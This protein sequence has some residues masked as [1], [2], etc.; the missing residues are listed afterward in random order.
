MAEY[1]TDLRDLEFSLFEWLKIQDHIEDYG[2]ND[3]KD[4]INQ[5]DKFIGNEVYPTRTNGDEEGV[6]LKDGQVTV[7]ESFHRANQ[8]FYENGWFALGYP[9]DIGGMP[10]PHALSVACTS[11]ANGANVSWTMYYGLSRAAMNVIHQVGSD[12]Q[13]NKYI[14]KMMEGSWGG[15]MCLTEAGAGSDVGA[16][17][18]TATPVGEDKFKI[19]GVKIFISSGDNDLYKNIVHLVL[20]RTPG[21]P[22]GTKGL[23]L[24]IVPKNIINED[25]S[26]GEFN[27]VR[28]TK[29]EE[30]MGLHG[31]A[32]CELTFGAEGECIGEMIGNEHEGIINMFI[33]MNEARLLC[34]MQGESQANLAYMLTEQ[35]ANERVQFGTEI[36]KLH[37]VKRMMLKMRAMSRGLR[38]LNL[39]AANLFDKIHDDPSIENKVA[40]LTPICKS[41][42]SEAGFQV[43]ID[44][45]QVHGGYG[46]CSE[47]GIEQFARDTKIATIYEG[48]NAI[49]A[50]DFSTRKVLKDGG[51]TLNLFVQEIS[52]SLESAGD[53]W[54]AECAL[55]K[56]CLGDL[57]KIMARFG[58]DA[59]EKKM[60][61]IL[62]N[63]SDF[64]TYCGNLVLSWLLLENALLSRGKEDD[65]Y[66]SK[67]VDFKT[68]CQHYLTTNK[69][70][71]HTLTGFE[72]DLSTVEL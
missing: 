64:L 55:I 47:Y 1:K 45:I 42:G 12:D 44:A 66:K 56:E 34:G 22:E 23:S 65:Y 40:F 18:T 61:S 10:V 7:P 4:I 49:Q 62:F 51:K 9:E 2:E 33:M 6:E 71:L 27:N 67:I 25:G 48:T 53:D 19:N 52:S 41:I 69:G 50:L 43:C 29:V 11:I 5:Y 30:K 57:Q 39:Y 46:Y 24:F 58:K 68:F 54:K 72:E 26:S 16:A 17:K 70:L 14:P 13:K 37:D 36:N 35:F 31:Q 63:S 38:A 28:C 60:D 20:A 8:Q 21:S 3:L 32:T 59:S 15:T